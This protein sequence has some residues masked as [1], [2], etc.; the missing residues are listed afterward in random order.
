MRIMSNFHDYYDGVQAYGHDSQKCYVRHQKVIEVPKIDFPLIPV[1]SRN[2]YLRFETGFIGV[3]GKIYPVIEWYC[4][5]SWW[6]TARCGCKVLRKKNVEAKEIGTTQKAIKHY[7]DH[8]RLDD[9][10]MKKLVGKRWQKK[11]DDD[12]R[13]LE[14][15]GQMIQ[16]NEVFINLGVPVFVI[17]PSLYYAERWTRVQKKSPTVSIILNASL[18]DYNFHKIMDTWT[19]Y[20]EIDMFI[21]NVLV[22]DTE[23]NVPS[24]TDVDVAQSKGYDKWSFRKEPEE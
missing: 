21:G 24:G 23:V 5:S 3:A 15:M 11:V 2:K 22:K 10:K 19:T 18:K 6:G 20:Q 7:E 14:N 13:K 16:D 9:K 1:S 4:A 12:L 8:L 17:K